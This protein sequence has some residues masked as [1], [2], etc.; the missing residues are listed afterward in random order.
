ML[1]LDAL[2]SKYDQAHPPPPLDDR[3]TRVITVRLPRALHLRLRA[4]A[5]EKNTSLNRLCCAVLDGVQLPEPEAVEEMPA[6]EL[7]GVAYTTPETEL[8][9]A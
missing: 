2:I 3:G 1:E 9:N 4:V 6:A 8:V 7:T 5:H